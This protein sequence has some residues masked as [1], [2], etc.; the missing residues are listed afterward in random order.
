MTFVARRVKNFRDVLFEKELDAIVLASYRGFGPHDGN[1][2]FYYLTNLL[3]RFSTYFLILTEDEQ[4]VWVEQSDLGRANEQSWIKGIDVME[5][6]SKNSHTP[7]EFGSILKKHVKGMVGGKKEIRVGLD[8]RYLQA[9]V[10]PSLA[11]DGI[12]V[13]DVA[14]DLELSRLVKDE[15]E[16]EHIRKAAAIVDTGVAKVMEGVQEG[17]SEIELAALAE[18]GMRRE[19]AE[20]FWWKTLINSG[21]DAQSWAD[22]PTKRKIGTGDLVGMDFTPVYQGY[23]ADIGRSFVF[24]KPNPKQLEVLE[25]TKKSLDAGISVL[26]DGVTIREI[27]KAATDVVKGSKYE[28]FFTGPGHCIGLYSDVYP[29]F[30][31]SIAKVPSLPKSH[32]DRRFAKGMT[33]AMEVVLTVP[34]V[35]R[36]CIE[37]DYLITA[38]GSERLTTADITFGTN[39]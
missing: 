8:G 27:V 23:A 36:V 30:F 7:A 1:Y 5:S 12:D 3:R 25:L 29:G 33:V 31:F 2:N 18:Y 24:G 34:G 38:R 21:P 10:V 16:L 28:K 13:L 20:C 19:G 37:D 32:L 6:P 17:T 26:R 39:R 11:G 9:S 22:S 4:G 15:L 14:E 35:G